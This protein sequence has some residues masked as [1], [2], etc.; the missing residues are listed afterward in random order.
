MALDATGRQR[1]AKIAGKASGKV[2]QRGMRQRDA[3]IALAFAYLS[4]KSQSVA[5]TRKA[6]IFL[7]GLGHGVNLPE[8]VD[9]LRFLAQ[10]IALTTKRIR[11]ILKMHAD[12]I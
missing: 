11:Q 6:I 1:R 3:N 8:D 4:G 7:T 9:P 5:D 10:A 2:R 12:I